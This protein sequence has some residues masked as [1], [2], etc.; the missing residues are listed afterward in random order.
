[1]YLISPKPTF[2]SEN[3]TAAYQL[4]FHFGWYSHGR[5]PIFERPDVSAAVSEYL[6]DI[7]RRHKYHLLETDVESLVVR[8]L[9]SLRPNQ[10]PSKE[11]N[12]VRGNL[13]KHIAEEL[14]LRNLWSRGK[15]VRS[16]GSVSA[17]V[18]RRYVAQQFEHH[19]AAH[20]RN[21]ERALVAGFH[22]PRGASLLRKDSHS[23]FEYNLHIVVVTERRTEFLDLEVA[24]AL[25][26]FWRRVCEK[27][28]WIVWD[29]E[30]VADHAHLV[31]GLRLT[32]AAE[33]V[34][35]SLLNNAEYFCHSRY[36]AAMRDA[37]W[38]HSGVLVCT[39]VPEVQR[40]RL[41]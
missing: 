13:A 11:T 25:I 15:F 16:L 19:R 41:K 30:I 28:Q 33:Q 3:T 32:D 18:I 40:Q 39:S 35:L 36:A 37:G 4:R 31:L 26:A 21:P 1:M 17:E 38:Q 20:T 10:S 23:I 5:Q 34:A 6:P 8:S 2:N 12:I 9:I 22:S 7:A 29:I 27:Y 24:E 14:S